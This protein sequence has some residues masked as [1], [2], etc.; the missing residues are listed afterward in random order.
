MREY[1]YLEFL[2]PIHDYL[3]TIKRREVVFD[4]VIPL[5][6]GIL[7]YFFVLKG[8]KYT[9]SIK[10]LNGYIISLLGILIG[11]SITSITL[12]VTS[13]NKNVEEL[14][15]KPSDNRKI[16]TQVINLYQLILI[17]FTFVLMVEVFTLAINLI[18]ALVDASGTK[19]ADYWTIFYTLNTFLFSSIIL[20]SVRNTTNIYFVFMKKNKK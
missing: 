13:S 2:I 17:N 15:L 8:S 16:G 10:Q 12:L 11:F 4:W 18:Y 9:D 14:Q 6:L 3:V 20:M 19:M 7:I 1:I 5:L